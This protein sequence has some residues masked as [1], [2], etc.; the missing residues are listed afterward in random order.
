MG[1]EQL[2]NFIV[3]RLLVDTAVIEH[4]FA[5]ELGHAVLVLEISHF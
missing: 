1:T 4:G 5:H 3:L 2:E